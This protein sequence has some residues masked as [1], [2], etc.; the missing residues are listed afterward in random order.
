MAV[1]PDDPATTADDLMALLAHADE[2]AKKTDYL[3]TP[4][5]LGTT[6]YLARLPDNSWQR[7]LPLKL[8]KNFRLKVFC[9]DFGSFAKISASLLK[10][11]RPKVGGTAPPL[12]YAAILSSV[13]NWDKDESWGDIP[14]EED[15]NQQ[16]PQQLVQ[17]R[18]ELTCEGAGG[19]DVHD[20][21]VDA[22]RRREIRRVLPPLESRNENSRTRFYSY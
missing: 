8:Y 4:P 6:V 17:E 10:A 11:Y 3:S 1:T 20:F 7:V 13:E 21:R 14:M 2:L 9:L 16:Q 18:K 19:G 15:N 5:K 22:I 12:G